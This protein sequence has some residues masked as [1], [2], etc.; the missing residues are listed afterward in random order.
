MT[1]KEL[2]KL[3]TETFQLTNSNAKAIQELKESQKETY[4]QIKETDKQLKITD[5]KLRWVWLTQWAISEEII[6]E[7]FKQAFKQEWEEITTIQR[8]I[9]AFKQWKNTAEAEIDIIWINGSKVFLWEVK[10][11]LT[12]KHVNKFINET[13][14]KFKKYLHKQRYGWLDIYGVVWAR[15]FADKEVKEYAKDN[16]L[17]IIKEQHN[18]NARILKESLK[19]VKSF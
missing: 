6:S 3:I 18:W 11:K 5:N 7:N 10:T 2:K 15:V 4:K 17:Y 8:N 9:E 12:K 14:P 13:I 1:D 19:T 16:G